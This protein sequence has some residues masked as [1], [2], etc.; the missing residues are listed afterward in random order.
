MKISALKD[1]SCELKGFQRGHNI[2]YQALRI[3][4]V[5]FQINRIR[6]LFGVDRNLFF[7]ITNEGRIMNQS[8]WGII[9]TFCLALFIYG[10]CTTMQDVNVPKSNMR[11]QMALQRHLSKLNKENE[12]LQ[13]VL[14]ESSVIN[15]ETGDVLENNFVTNENIPE[16]NRLL[17]QFKRVNLE[18]QNALNAFD[19]TVK[20]DAA[21]NTEINQMLDGIAIECKQQQDRIDRA[22]E[23]LDEGEDEWRYDNIHIGILADYHTGTLNFLDS[24]VDYD[25]EYLGNAAS[26]YIQIVGN[27]H[28][29]IGYRYT[30]LNGRADSD[31]YKKR[32]SDWEYAK[33]ELYL[34]TFSLGYRLYGIKTFNIIPQIKLGVGEAKTISCFESGGCDDSDTNTTYDVNLVGFELPFY[35]QLSSAFSWGFNIAY[36][37]IDFNTYKVYVNGDEQDLDDD[38]SDSY[39]ET[40]SVGIMLGFAW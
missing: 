36:N 8:P 20:D 22:R 23:L 40:A 30:V 19:K 3:N 12:K 33:V 11:K 14:K 16:I 10:G 29:A 37:K 4:V 15:V 35:H 25:L 9:L 6:Y 7:T 27:Y 26:A 21:K 1:I 18:T 17:Q 28:T 13:K 38:E 24:G 39:L 34:H 2:G 31:E 32:I 5:L